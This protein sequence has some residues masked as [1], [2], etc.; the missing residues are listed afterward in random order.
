MTQLTFA[1]SNDELTERLQSAA[2]AAGEIAASSL[3]AVPTASLLE[4]LDRRG[5][6][7]RPRRQRVVVTTGFVIAVCGLVALLV[8]TLP[9]NH[10]VAPTPPVTKPA[11][12]PRSLGDAFVDP[13]AS[14]DFLNSSTGYVFTDPGGGSPGLI[15]KTSNGG[16]SWKEVLQANSSFIG[17]DFVDPD[18]GWVVGDQELLATTDGGDT[19]ADLR[20][21][22]G[23]FQFVDFATPSYGWAI[24][25]YGTLMATIDAG[26][27]WKPVSTSAPVLAACLASP[28]SGWAV[29]S[30]GGYVVGTADLG[31]SW[32]FQF[33][34][35]P[36]PLTSVQLRCSS[37][38]AFLAG[39]IGQGHGKATYDVARDSGPPDDADWSAVPR[40]DV[41][42]AGFITGISL[43]GGQISVMSDCGNQC[44]ENH[45]YLASSTDGGRSFRFVQFE[46]PSNIYSADLSFPTPV[47]W[48]GSHWELDS[49]RV[50]PSSLHRTAA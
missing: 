5:R 31:K 15:T 46:N 25:S 12:G 19:W 34:L 28:T 27:S 7:R 44:N 8:V 18:H 32:S 40:K 50:T 33:G 43:E 13:N 9:G 38:E 36:G 22:D 47:E 23:G 16:L 6:E 49:T 37:N 17:L 29:L 1:R 14:V 2:G 24:T 20:E 26:K 21:P 48:L 30:K 11:P 41:N 10:S 42:D 45:A 39:L 4:A 3:A 35:S